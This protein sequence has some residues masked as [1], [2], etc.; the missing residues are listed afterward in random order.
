[1]PVI[2]GGS[3][4]R[5]TPRIAATYA[6]EFN[7]PF[8]SLEETAAQFGRVREACAVTGRSL[9][10]S[11]AQTLLVGRDDAEVRRRAERL[12]GYGEHVRQHGLSGTV[13]EVVDKAARFGE[14]GATRLYLQLLDLSDLDQLELVASDVAPQLG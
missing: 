2:V 9:V 1:V 4:Q 7:L 6:D 8:A 3:G 14:A 10:L 5:R 13:A 11:A 12:G